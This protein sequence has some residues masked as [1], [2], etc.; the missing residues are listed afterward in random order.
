MILDEIVLKTKERYKDKL[1][2]ISLIKEKAFN[3]V[4]ENPNFFYEAIEKMEFP[5]YVNVKKLLHQRG[6]LVRIFL[7]LI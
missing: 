2:N 3:R 5:L 7:I 1:N 4:I 6:L